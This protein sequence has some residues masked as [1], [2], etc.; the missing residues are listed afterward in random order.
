MS[1]VDVLVI[2]KI[3]FLIGNIFLFIKVFVL[4]LKGYNKIILVL[5]DI[6]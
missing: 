5:I 4:F 1:I 6:F 3:I 2:L